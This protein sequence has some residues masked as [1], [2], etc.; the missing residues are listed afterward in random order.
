MANRFQRR[1]VIAEDNTRA[2]NFD[3]IVETGHVPL[4]RTIPEDLDVGKLE[5][6]RHRLDQYIDFSSDDAF[7]RALARMELATQL[8]AQRELSDLLEKPVWDRQDRV[9][10]ERE[11]SRIVS[12][13]MDKVPGLDSYRHRPLEGLDAPIADVRATRLNDLSVDIENNTTTIE[14]DCETMSIIEGIVLRNVEHDLLPAYEAVA[15]DNLRYAGSYFYVRGN[16]SLNVRVREPGGHAWIASSVTGNFIEA[17][18]DPSTHSRNRQYREHSDPGYGFDDLMA[19]RIAHMQGSEIYGPSDMFAGDVAH[20]R[21]G[22]GELP[23]VQNIYG[24]LVAATAIL[25]DDWVRQVSPVTT[26]FAVPARELNAII[27]ETP[28]EVRD[29]LG[30]QVEDSGFVNTSMPT[31]PLHNRIAGSRFNQELS[32]LTRSKYLHFVMDDAETLMNEAAK[33]MHS[34]ITRIERTL[35]PDE[36]VEVLARNNSFRMMHGYV[37]EINAQRPLASDPSASYSPPNEA[38]ENAWRG[39]EL[40]IRNA[41]EYGDLISVIQDIE[42]L[43]ARV[44]ER[45]GAA[46]LESGDAMRTT[47]FSDN[48]QEPHR[49]A[50]GLRESPIQENSSSNRRR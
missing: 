28:T 41:S 43:E 30:V 24:S 17:T 16:A 26:I 47:P 22:A 31:H 5:E 39:L 3:L 33:R 50:H 45:E 48:S 10:W 9:R 32:Q 8:R 29:A 37:A 27:S 7:T 25:D 40:T 36:I 23:Q 49:P 46:N 1:D 6:E 19:G 20:V 15:E 21:W 38:E 2:I 13:E 14:H 12:E 4:Y 34:R 11:L 18:Y 35:E 44:A 42:A